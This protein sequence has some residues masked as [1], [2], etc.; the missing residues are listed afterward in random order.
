MHTSVPMRT[1]ASDPSIRNG[2]QRNAAVNSMKKSGGQLRVVSAR[3]LTAC[4]RA[5]ISKNQHVAFCLRFM[6]PGSVRQKAVRQKYVLFPLFD[7]FTSSVLRHGCTT[8][9]RRSPTE[10]TQSHW[11]TLQINEND[12]RYPWKSQ[13]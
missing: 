4:S 7:T 13:Q 12:T 6:L 9:P 5:C 11:S 10:F 8:L 1:H 2:V 3:V